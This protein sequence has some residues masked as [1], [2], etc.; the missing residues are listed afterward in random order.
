[1]PPKIPITQGG[2]PPN[3][4][5]PQLL[6]CAPG[7]SWRQRICAGTP[8]SGAIAMQHREGLNTRTVSPLTILWGSA[9]STILGRAAPTRTSVTQPAALPTRPS[10]RSRFS[11]DGADLPSTPR[12][13]CTPAQSRPCH[14]WHMAPV[15]QW[16]HCVSGPIT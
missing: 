6:V 4:F 9:W 13:S 8:H 11:C 1:M 3:I 15:Y 5:A 16:P 14:L 12:R 7:A 10:G 2:C